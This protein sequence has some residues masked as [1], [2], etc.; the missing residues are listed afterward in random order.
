MVL[1]LY[2]YYNNHELSLFGRAMYSA[3]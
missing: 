1:C 2:R 3:F